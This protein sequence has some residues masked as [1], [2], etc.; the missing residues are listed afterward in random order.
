MI[1]KK[2]IFYL[3]FVLGYILIICKGVPVNYD[4][5]VFHIGL[6]AKGNSTDINHAF[7]DYQKLLVYLASW[8]ILVFILYRFS[9]EVKIKK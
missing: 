6:F 1:T 7:I 2:G 3:L 9:N 8:G 4:K 5:S